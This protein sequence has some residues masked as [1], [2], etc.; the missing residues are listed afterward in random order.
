[1]A[2]ANAELGRV[3]IL[4]NNAGIAL[5][6]TIEAGNSSDWRR[7]FDLNVL[8]LLYA[9]H[10]VLPLFFSL[11]SGKSTLIFICSKAFTLVI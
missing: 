7:S 3:D 4:V 11:I 6:G 1:M 10:A 8:G 9:T 2:K 5:L